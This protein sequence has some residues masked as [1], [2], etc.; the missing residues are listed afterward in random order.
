MSRSICFA[1][2]A[3]M[4]AGCISSD[5]PT[6]I[7]TSGSTDYFPLKVGNRWY[8]GGYMRGNPTDTTNTVHIAEVIGTRVINQRLCF[9]MLNRFYQAGGDSPSFVDT[10]YFTVD[11]DSLL[12]VNKDSSSFRFS[13]DAI[14]SLTKGE[15]FTQEVG[16]A[17]NAFHFRVTV[18]DRND[19]TITFFYDAPNI[20]DEEHQKTY[21]RGAGIVDSHS[22]AWGIGERLV[23]VEFEQAS[24]EM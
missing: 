19:S 17:G 16:V 24:Q 22:T 8:Y 14:F 18:V 9:V 2:F 4:F 20:V 21:K 12:S 15:E 6:G 7:A 10:S 11:G 5:S 23:K 13:V 3:T 1:L